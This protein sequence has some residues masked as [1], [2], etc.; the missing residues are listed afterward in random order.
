MALAAG[1]ATDEDPVLLGGFSMANNV[2]QKHVSVVDE[3]GVRQA[4]ATNYD[5]NAVSESEGTT[6]FSSKQKAYPADFLRNLLTIDLTVRGIKHYKENIRSLDAISLHRE[7]Q[8]VHGMP[9]EF[10]RML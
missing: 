8:N 1:G 6:S 10:H 2:M 3:I 9:P 4:N 7:P 5:I